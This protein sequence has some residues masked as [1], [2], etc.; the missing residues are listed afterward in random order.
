M[1][2]MSHLKMSIPFTVPPK[3]IE[4]RFRAPCEG[5]LSAVTF[6]VY[7]CNNVQHSAMNLERICCILP[8][9]VILSTQRGCLIWKCPSRSPYH[10][11]QS[12]HDFGPRA[13]EA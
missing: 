6:K 5:G 2:G 13:R 7:Q 4:A 9:L 11:R 12:N 3:T 8:V 10:L 1:T